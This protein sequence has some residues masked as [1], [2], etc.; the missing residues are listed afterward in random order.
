M[1]VQR[2]AER[3]GLIYLFN[4][5]KLIRNPL[6]CASYYLA[7]G[8]NIDARDP[9]PGHPPLTALTY[10]IKQNDLRLASFLIDHGASLKKPAGRNHLKPLP[11]A[12]NLAFS[13]PSVNRNE[14]IGLLTDALA[15]R[16]DVASR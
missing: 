8:L 1:S 2:L 7:R 6:E 13:Y 10:A 5:R 4:R 15:T 9:R 12:Y 3:G 11:F 14:M 16:S